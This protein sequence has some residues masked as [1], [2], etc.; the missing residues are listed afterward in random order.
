MGIENNVT[1]E[2]AAIKSIAESLS[3]SSK[4]N[5]QNMMSAT[6]VGAGV[7]TTVT[8]NGNRSSLA[9]QQDVMT[10]ERRLSSLENG[11]NTILTRLD[12]LGQTMTQQHGGG[13]STLE[14]KK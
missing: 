11:L 13:G 1:K 6:A 2:I 14:K 7:G 9:T 4:L 8:G 5:G 12:G 3:T 10:L